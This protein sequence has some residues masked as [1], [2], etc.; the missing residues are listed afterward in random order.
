MDK[1]DQT[2]LENLLDALCEDIMELTDEEVRAECIEDG[3]DPDV[4][5][6]EVR[7]VIDKTITKWRE[8][9]EVERGRG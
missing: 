3:K 9:Q 1:N 5:A 4:V 2:A 8:Q 6:V 7:A